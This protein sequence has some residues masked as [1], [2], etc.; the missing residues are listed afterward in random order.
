MLYEKDGEKEGE[1]ER[2]K[3]RKKEGKIERIYFVSRVLGVMAF[4]HKTQANV[5]GSIFGQGGLS[6]SIFLL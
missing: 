5:M 4:F 1:K 2:K 6:T 3:E